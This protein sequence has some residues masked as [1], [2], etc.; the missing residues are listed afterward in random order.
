MFSQDEIETQEELD[1]TTN[2]SNPMYESQ[3]DS[4]MQPQEDLHARPYIP[5]EPAPLQAFDSKVWGLYLITFI[6]S[7]EFTEIWV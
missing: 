3:L 2:F 1:K 6:I 5:A 4:D 7:E